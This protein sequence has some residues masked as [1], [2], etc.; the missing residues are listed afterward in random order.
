MSKGRKKSNKIDIFILE[1][2]LPSTR[3][4]STVR[5]EGRGG[6]DGGGGWGEGFTKQEK[7]RLSF[8]GFYHSS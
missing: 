4:Q 1:V 3:N 2:L 6:R 8:A 5:G 7:A